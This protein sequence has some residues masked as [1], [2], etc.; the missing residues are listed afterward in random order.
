M[1]VAGSVGAA[2]LGSTPR[3]R[4]SRQPSASTPP[5]RVSSPPFSSDETHVS[6]HSSTAAYTVDD[7]V[8]VMVCVSLHKIDSEMEAL[9]AERSQA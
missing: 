4:C 5:E 1:T 9:T 8:M 6:Q 3:Q 2:S 7:H